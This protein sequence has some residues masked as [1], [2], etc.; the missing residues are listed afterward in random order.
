MLISVG[1]ELSKINKL[2]V[3]GF[4]EAYFISKVCV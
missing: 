4:R 2:Y 3:A 1:S